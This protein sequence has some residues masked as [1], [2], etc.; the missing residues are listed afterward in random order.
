MTSELWVKV[1]IF[2][3]H[4][5]ATTNRYTWQHPLGFSAG[6]YRKRGYVKAE[7]NYL[8]RNTSD[9]EQ[10][11]TGLETDWGSW[12]YFRRAGMTCGDDMGGFEDGEI[13]S[14]HEIE[15][16]PNNL[17]HTLHLNACE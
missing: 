14:L 7:I 1:D 11:L 8:F 3:R 6:W 4:Q 2:G 12:V 17:I 9:C 5:V 10:G 15:C 16:S 13:H